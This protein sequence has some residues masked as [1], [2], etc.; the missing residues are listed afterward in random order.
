MQ[1]VKDKGVQRAAERKPEGSSAAAIEEPSHGHR[2]WCSAAT[3]DEDVGAITMPASDADHDSGYGSSRSGETL[4]HT[5]CVGSPDG[6]GLGDSPGR[7]V[8]H[9]DVM[10]FSVS[11]DGDEFG[12]GCHGRS[13]SGGSRTSGVTC[14][15]TFSLSMGDED[16]ATVSGTAFMQPP[17]SPFVGI[18]FS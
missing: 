4:S 1:Q 11:T 8:F 7:S 2:R 16:D 15:D 3:V 14:D 6:V 13:C 17:F 5:G 10:S 9:N 18:N 12:A